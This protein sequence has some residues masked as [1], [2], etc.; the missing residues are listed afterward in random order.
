MKP[1]SVIKIGGNV[2]DNPEALDAFLDD[3]IAMPNDK[4]LV[5]GG[6]VMASQT[7]RRL[8]IEPRMVE[9]RRITDEQT[10]KVAVSVYAGWLN[11]TIVA[12]L[13]ARRCNALGL[14]GADGDI[15][16]AD[17][18]PK[19]P[20]DFGFVGDVRSVDIK[21]LDMLLEQGI[22]PVLCAVTHDRK[23]TLLNTNAD[24]IAS[25]VA[26]AMAAI[27][28]V[29]LTFCFEKNGVLA[30]PEDENSVIPNID[31]TSFAEMKAS[32]AVS[33]GMIPKLDNAFAAIDAGVKRVIIKNSANLGKAI[34]T[35][36]E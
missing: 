22:T 3:F 36:I 33:A 9:G 30:D 2:V 24:T 32:G 13:Q 12:K 16:E 17:I 5:H 21:F 25:R 19:E 6:G 27:R 29:S 11:K 35:V 10:L 14:S 4:I 28:Q 1:L 20:I 8:G 34:G 23:G 31:R 26:R 18:R 15:I 7:L